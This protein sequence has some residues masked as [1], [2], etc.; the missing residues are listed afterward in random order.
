MPAQTDEMIR[1]LALF[2]EENPFPILRVDGGGIL[3]YANRA[4]GKLLKQWQ[5]AV[6]GTV[7]AFVM[8]ELSKALQREVRRE[9]LTR[10]GTRD[11]SFSLVP[12]VERGYVNF[13]GCDVTQKKQFEADLVQSREFL[14]QAQ[15]VAHLGSWE[16]DLVA[17]KITWS[18]EV[19]RIFGLQPQEFLASYEA[20][21]DAVH[22]DDR[23]AVSEAYSSSLREGRV[24][25][26]IEH[27]IVRKRS[28]EI[29]YVHEKCEHL[30]DTDG[31][32]VRS[33][34]MVQD[35][36]DRKRRDNEIA[37]LHTDLNVRAE[38]LEEANQELETF[39]YTVAH[40]LRKPLA[41]IS[42]YSELLRDRGEN[43]DKQSLRFLEVIHESALSMGQLIEAL[44]TFSQL[45]HAEMCQEEVNLSALARSA[46]KELEL[47]E[48][49]RRVKV[50]VSE[51]M[52]VNGDA[53]LLKVVVN[54]LIGNA[55]KFTESCEKAVIELGTTVIDGT[56][57]FFVRD[58]G[59][60]FDLDCAK[61]LFVPFRRCM[62]AE[63]T[64]G[65]GIGLAT[66]ERII[67][68]HG[69]RIW[70]VAESGKGATFYFTF[71]LGATRRI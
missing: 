23:V 41:L 40:D 27:R 45:A 14:N 8:I 52:M 54:N 37:R 59:V 57:T 21:L 15:K 6:G 44:L 47:A 13:Y 66:V 1:N 39:N 71:S 18:D 11:F 63:D 58:N 31:K 24:S 17:D 28:G 51:E 46:A 42:G 32:I 12:I 65:F 43:L 7:P 20:F 19:Y 30:R 9:L 50:R 10:C 2:P 55:W 25:Y 67:H 33:V 4:A 34:G 60:G 26:E 68:R 70:A 35:I 56:K 16:L 5:C 61:S 3:L 22:P 29:R 36:T 64:K 48:P 53:D 38:E 62:G 69:G 49:H